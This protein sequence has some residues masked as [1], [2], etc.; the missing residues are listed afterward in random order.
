MEKPKF[1]SRT[2]LADFLSKIAFFSSEYSWLLSGCYSSVG[3]GKFPL[4]LL[5]CRPRRRKLISVA[6]ETQDWKAQG[7]LDW[8]KRKTDDLQIFM[9]NT[10]IFVQ[11]E[12][13][14]LSSLPCP[15]LLFLLPIRSRPWIIDR[16]LYN[17]N[18]LNRPKAQRGC[19]SQEERSRKE[20]DRRKGERK[21]LRNSN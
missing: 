12:R 6:A 11:R 17:T 15:S 9:T 4:L 8:C 7:P 1:L 20:E 18:S 21:G 14:P 2:T 19:Q 16:Q 5:F 10:I 3:P 13:S